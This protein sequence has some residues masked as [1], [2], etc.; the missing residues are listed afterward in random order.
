MTTSSKK[1]TSMDSVTIESITGIEVP[2]V[3]IAPVKNTR[4]RRWM[5]T[6]SAEQYNAE[7]IKCQLDKYTTY[8]GQQERGSKTGYIHY[9]VFI[10][11][12]NPIAFST[13]KKKFPTAHIE[14]VTDPQATL[15]YVTKELTAYPT[16]NPVRF[17]KGTFKF[18][19]K[20][21][22]SR[23]VKA[24]FDDLYGMVLAG[25]SLEHLM[26]ELPQAAWH[27]R[28][29]AAV[30]AAVLADKY[31]KK[32]RDVTVTYIWGVTGAGKTHSVYSKHGFED[33]YVIDDYVNPFDNYSGQPVIV[34]DEFHSSISNFGYLLKLTDKWPV[35]LQARYHNKWAGFNHV[36]IIS[37]EPLES[38]YQTIQETKPATWNALLRRID[39]IIYMGTP[40]SPEDETPTVK[41]PA[42]RKTS[43]AKQSQ[44]AKKVPAKK[45]TTAAKKPATKRPTRSIAIEDLQF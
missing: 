37:N 24:N 7:Q 33:V 15:N 17:Q 5:L 31:S 14:E 20:E 32:E 45:A 25:N 23:A 3:N 1:K 2:S 4:N 13:L 29:L 10:E 34:F 40:Y 36:Y 38:Q 11:H 43:T 22:K 18:R 35:K 26:L 21:A 44:T 16:A 19:V 9:H 27:E 42:T 28:K 12:R 6:L 30:E 39:N 8:A 41:K